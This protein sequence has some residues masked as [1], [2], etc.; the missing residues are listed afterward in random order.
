MLLTTKE[1]RDIEVV[2][3]ERLKVDYTNFSDDFSAGGW[4]MSL[5]RCISTAFRTFIRLSLR[6]SRLMR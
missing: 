4:R 6:S 5:R 3:A 2:L 1:L